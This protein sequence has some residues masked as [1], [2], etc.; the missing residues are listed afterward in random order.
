MN[1]LYSFLLPGLIVP[2]VLS[3]TLVTLTLRLHWQGAWGLA[4]VWLISYFWLRGLPNPPPREAVDW[5]WLIGFATLAAGALPIAP[6]GRWLLLSGLLALYLA[7]I[8]WPVARHDASIMT[9]VELLVLI[10]AGTSLI[11]RLIDGYTAMFPA[12]SMA[13]ISISYAATAALG[14]SLLIGLLSSAL[15]ATLGGFALY[16]ATIKKKMT[17]LPIRAALLA[18][19]WLLCLMLIGRVYAE[20]PL[21]SLALLL[22]AL[23]ASQVLRVRGFWQ[24]TLITGIP[25]VSAIAWCVLIQG[26]SSYY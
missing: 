20:L 11:H 23:V 15:A 19:I 24:A 16:E 7:V 4:L 2:L 25:A 9:L 3:L 22:A 12:L 26:S 10:I 6:R 8:V 13:I 1:T 21:G 14:G 17:L 5:L 18:N